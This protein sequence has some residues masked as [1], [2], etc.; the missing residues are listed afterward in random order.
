MAAEHLAVFGHSDTK[1]PVAPVRHQLSSIEEEA[2][3][4][5]AMKGFTSS[6]VGR[7]MC[8]LKPC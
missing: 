5:G 1:S 2:T 8:D 6:C 3:T 7:S 4:E